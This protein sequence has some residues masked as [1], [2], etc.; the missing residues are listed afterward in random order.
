MPTLREL[1]ETIQRRPGVRAVVLLGTDG[2]VIETPVPPHDADT[3]AAHAPAV[4]TAAQQLGTAASAGDAQFVLIEFE[5][6]YGV[7]MRLTPRAILFVS[8]S[9]D[10]QLSDLLF[11][12]RRHR[13]PIAAIL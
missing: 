3:L 8:A 7:L 6:G 10:T 11:D 2:L 1:T 9:P 13:A 12:L 4:F 5:H